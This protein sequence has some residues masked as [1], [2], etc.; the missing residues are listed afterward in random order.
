LIIAIQP[1]RD[2]RIPHLCHAAGNDLAKCSLRHNWDQLGVGSSS[3][4]FHDRGVGLGIYE[5]RPAESIVRLRGYLWHAVS[6]EQREPFLQPC[7]VEMHRLLRL[8]PQ[9]NSE[10]RDLHDRNRPD[11]ASDDADPHP[12]APASSNPAERFVKAI[13]VGGGAARDGREC[14][15]LAGGERLQQAGIGG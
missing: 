11:Q 15:A 12:H 1:R 8:P 6:L 13:G 5:D 3:K 2:D 14:S 4:A 10:A 7:D 9:R